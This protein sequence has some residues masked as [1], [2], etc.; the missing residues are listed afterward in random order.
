MI[1]I[2]ELI[3]FRIFSVWVVFFFIVFDVIDFSFL[4]GEVFLL[5]LRNFWVLGFQDIV[6]LGDCIENWIFFFKNYDISSV[7]FSFYKNYDMG[8]I[9]IWIILYGSLVMC[10]DL[11]LGLIMDNDLI[12]DCG[13]FVMI[14]EKG[15]IV[16]IDKG[17]RIEDLCYLKG[18]LYNCLLFKFD[19]Q[20]EESDISKNF[21]VVILRIYNENYIGRMRD[22]FIFNVCQLKSRC[23]I[24]CCVYKVFVYI[25]NMLFFQ[26]SFK[27]VV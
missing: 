25:V 20:Y 6:F 16:L 9:G 5:L 3:Q 23:D 24:F 18:F 8:K 12:L 15:I 10:I 13:V 21:D 11:Y 26:I 7:I 2:S 17:F 27:E 4:F 14:K 1:S 19:M 22:W